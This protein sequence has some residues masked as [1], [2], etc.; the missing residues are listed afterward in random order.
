MYEQPN[1]DQGIFTPNEDAAT[2]TAKPFPVPEFTCPK[3]FKAFKSAPALRMHNVRKHTKGWETGQNFKKKKSRGTTGM[4]L[5]SW[6][7][8]RRKQ[9]QRTWAAKKKAATPPS[10]VNQGNNPGVMFCPRCGCNIKVVAAA[11]AFSENRP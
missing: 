6:T 4:K 2:E 5:G 7:P 3:C 8:E 10:Q 1:T 11:I 9:F